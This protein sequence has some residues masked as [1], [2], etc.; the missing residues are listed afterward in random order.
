VA[1]NFVWLKIGCFGVIA[2][3]LFVIIMHACVSHFVFISKH[4]NTLALAISVVLA[5]FVRTALI[6]FDYNYKSKSRAALTTNRCCALYALRPIR[7]PVPLFRCTFEF[8]S[9]VFLLGNAIAPI[10]WS[11]L[12][13][14]GPAARS[15]PPV[16]SLRSS[17]CLSRSP[18][19]SSGALGVSWIL[20]WCSCSIVVA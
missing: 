8:F 5:L 6:P 16:L 20:Q 9:R 11:L 17:W 10:F 12:D 2:Y 15:D 13:P 4:S 18:R 14:C 19:V 1:L 7:M 3:V